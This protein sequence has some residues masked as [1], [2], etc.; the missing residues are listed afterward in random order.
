M[1]FVPPEEAVRCVKSH[2]RVF[3]HGVAAVASGEAD[4]VPVFLSEVPARAA[5]GREERHLYPALEQVTTEAERD[6]ILSRLFG[7]KPRG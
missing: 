6:G 2:D 3:V 4:Y 7:L 1:K 5:R